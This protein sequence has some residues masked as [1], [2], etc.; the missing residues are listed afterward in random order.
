MKD[1]VAR[2]HGAG[3]GTGCC[4]GDVLRRRGV[5]GLFSSDLEQAAFAPIGGRVGDHTSARM[6]LRLF[7]SA[8]GDKGTS[9]GRVEPGERSLG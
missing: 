7:P 6:G 2:D 5:E 4:H 1:K 3:D 9:R 8:A